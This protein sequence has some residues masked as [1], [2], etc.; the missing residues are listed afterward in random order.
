MPLIKEYKEYIALFI[1]GTIAIF[2]SA[3]I[4]FS[5]VM[6]GV[7]SYFYLQIQKCNH[8]KQV[9]K[10]SIAFGLGYYL[11]NTYW[12]SLS[13]FQDL[14]FI[15]LLPLSLTIIP[16]YY[17]LFLAVCMAF[18][19]IISDKIPNN[20]MKVVSFAIFWI[21]HE[22]M[23]ANMLFPFPWWPIGMTVG[24]ID[25]W[26]Q[27]LGIISIYFFGFF[28]ILL[29]LSPV[30]IK[31]K[32]ILWQKISAIIFIILIHT[33]FI[34]YGHFQL[35]RNEK[36]ELPFNIAM[37][38][39]NLT[40]FE[41]WKDIKHGLIKHY[42]LTSKITTNKHNNKPNLIVWAETS[43]PY[44]I[45]KD[46]KYN[47]NNNYKIKNIDEFINS[48][49]IRS[50]EKYFSAI[51]K[52]IDKNDKIIFGAVGV[53]NNGE[54]HTNSAFLLGQSGIENIY[55]KMN[56]VP[57]GEYVP[58]LP[59]KLGFLPSF[60]P[61]KER[62]IWN[63]AGLKIIPLICYEVLFDTKIKKLHPDLI[64]NISND[65]WF[66][67]ST[68]PYQ[69]F[70]HAKVSAIRNGVPLIR[71]ANTGIS[72]IFDKRGRIVEKIDRKIENSSYLSH[73]NNP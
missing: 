65:G 12:I 55:D 49:D 24:N 33:I 21:L 18:N 40:Q 9:F 38:Q 72:A 22:K 73:Q 56:L 25:S 63:I 37:I 47:L 2:A 3:P 66:G 53:K 54:S 48:E 41:K 69:H 32:M 30:I 13:L 39:T 17:S 23:R 29:Y 43:I 57:F 71:V 10:L 16:L 68:G 45:N 5:F 67:N 20:L 11:V 27:P 52:L 60:D 1:V 59:I 6:F 44:F 50:D 64:V 58:F 8:W 42:N 36:I 34:T 46:E 7:V 19:K 15:A 51:T 4:Y 31:E 70:A 35:N 14:R 62:A 61:G 26:I 28:L